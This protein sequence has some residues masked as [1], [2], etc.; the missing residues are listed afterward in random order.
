M[1][2]P[3]PPDI[4]GSSPCLRGCQLKADE[5][6]IN[7]CV[8][9]GGPGVQSTIPMDSPLFQCPCLCQSVCDVTPYTPELS[10]SS[11]I[12]FVFMCSC[13]D[14]FGQRS[15]VAAPHLPS[16]SPHYPLC[17][18]LTMICHAQGR[19]TRNHPGS[20]ESF[21]PPHLRTCQKIPE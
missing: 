8:W 1:Q 6:L 15:K 12:L 19:S 16:L 13:C 3:S 4:R 14:D 18:Q 5:L 17:S 2:S 11:A 21:Q 10:T 20:Y 7:P 9:W